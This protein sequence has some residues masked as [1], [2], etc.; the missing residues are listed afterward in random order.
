MPTRYAVETDKEG[1][2]VLPDD[3]VGYAGLTDTVMFMG[4]RADL[5]DLGAG[6]RGAPPCRARARGPQ[7][8]G[9]ALPASQAPIDRL[10]HAERRA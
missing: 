8:G 4:A 6:G 7:Q 1:R 9:A 10:R 5:P 3:L 2:I